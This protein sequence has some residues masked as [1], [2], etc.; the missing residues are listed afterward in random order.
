[1]AR[2]TYARSSS[3]SRWRA[4]NARP[5]QGPPLP[6]VDSGPPRSPF[7]AGALEE[8]SL[9]P[10]DTS[11][12]FTSPPAPRPL[13]SNSLP[14]RHGR[15][16][17]E[18]VAFGPP[19]VLPSCPGAPPWT[20]SSSASSSKSRGALLRRRRLVP[21]SVADAK[22]AV[23]LLPPGFLEPRRP[24]LLVH[25]ELLV[26]LDLSPLSPV[27]GWLGSFKLLLRPSRVVV[28][29]A[30]VVRLGPCPC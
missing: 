28:A 23:G 10:L 25:G 7:R 22:L 13:L 19:R 14:R 5:K 3:S 24:P 6:T 12:T 15:P 29:V 8:H 11:S 4:A 17:V 2:P 20:A 26:R 30:V 18:L 9:D 21:F 16:L 1:M 27:S